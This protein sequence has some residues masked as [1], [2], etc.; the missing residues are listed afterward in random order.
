MAFVSRH[1]KGHDLKGLRKKGRTCETEGES[2]Q[3]RLTVAQDAVL[4]CVNRELR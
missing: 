2:L 1:G 4:G 3:G